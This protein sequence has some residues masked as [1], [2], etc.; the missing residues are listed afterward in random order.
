MPLDETVFI[1]GFPGFIAGRLLERL[2]REGGR[3][4][5]LVQSPFV[6]RARVE[7]GRIAHQTENP[8]SNFRILE[9]DIAQ[10]NLGMSQ[11]HLAIASSQ[12]TVIFHL[13]AIYDL[14]VARDIAMQVNV[15]GTRN[16]NELAQSLPNLRHYHYVSTCYV[17]GK[18]KG[19]ILETELK[20]AAGFRNYYEESKY[21]AEVEV[22]A[23][24]SI[25][26][27]TIHRPAVV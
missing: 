22:E 9:G 4:L 23:L 14:A 7:L 6:D 21:L 15:A 10:P 24:K 13:A 2:A 3:F 5:L 25:L 19:R 12:P 16:V 17:A 27:I 18:L 1:T 8:I 11:D 26:P 20:H